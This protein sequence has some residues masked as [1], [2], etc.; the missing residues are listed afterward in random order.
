MAIH[1]DR[2]DQPNID[3]NGKI[4]IKPEPEWNWEERKA[5]S[6]NFTIQFNALW[7]TRCSDFL[8]PQDIQKKHGI[9]S[10]KYLKN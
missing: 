4:M 6:R 7:M 9:L 8:P 2:M 3:E 5:V 10:K 1:S